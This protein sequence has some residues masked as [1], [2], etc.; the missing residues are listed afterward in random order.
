MKHVFT[1]MILLMWLT[2]TGGCESASIVYVHNT[3]A[4]VD[5][6]ASPS[7][8]STVKMSI[9]YDRETFSYV[10]RYTRPD[11]QA[12]AMAITAISRVN[13]DGLKEFKFGHMFS[14]G[15]SAVRLARKPIALRTITNQ[16]FQE[17][18]GNDNGGDQ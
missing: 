16:I 8:V 5:L 1:L 13:I 17:T 2:T 18:N 9:G 10:P 15:E 6:H 3:S 11:G 14:T 7:N 4:G 12:D